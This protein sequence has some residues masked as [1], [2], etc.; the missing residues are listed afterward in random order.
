MRRPVGVSA[1]QI[2]A[3]VA[4]GLRAVI[5]SQQMSRVGPQHTI[6]VLDGASVLE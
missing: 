3:V 5:A 4:G 2:A 6:L 1:A